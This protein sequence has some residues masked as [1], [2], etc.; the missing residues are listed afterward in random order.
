[1]YFYDGKTAPS[2]P[3]PHYRGLTITQT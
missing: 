2:G 3:V 1:M